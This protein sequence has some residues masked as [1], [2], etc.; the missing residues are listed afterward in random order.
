[1]LAALSFSD[2]T[3]TV[4][5]VRWRIGDKDLGHFGQLF[6]SLSGN[7]QPQMRWRLGRNEISD[8]SDSI[9]KSLEN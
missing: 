7:D 6:L 5:E 9:L 1:M 8:T 3:D 4:F 2:V